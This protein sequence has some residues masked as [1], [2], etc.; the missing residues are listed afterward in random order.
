M[1]LTICRI[2]LAYRLVF[3]LRFQFVPLRHARQTFVMYNVNTDTD[4]N[5]ESFA[6]DYNT[7]SIIIKSVGNDFRV[8][9]RQMTCENNLLA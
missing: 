8:P 4:D 1:T 2:M 5:G 3:N 6:R 7:P 9:T